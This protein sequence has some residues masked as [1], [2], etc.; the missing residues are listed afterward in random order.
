MPCFILF[1]HFSLSRSSTCHMFQ[2]NYRQVMKDDV[3]MRPD[4][5]LKRK[6]LGKVLNT[7]VCERQPV[8]LAV[9]QSL[10][11]SSKVKREKKKNTIKIQEERKFGGKGTRISIRE[12]CF[13]MYVAQKN[14]AYASKSEFR[15]CTCIWPL[16][17]IQRH[18]AAG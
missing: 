11:F 13:F 4:L 12:L 3:Q 16:K 9:T 2:H 6:L 10:F 7:S 1:I 8:V 17:C 18:A 14:N 15:H 5:S